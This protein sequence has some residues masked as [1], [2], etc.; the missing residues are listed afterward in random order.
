MTVE[1]ERTYPCVAFGKQPVVSVME[2]TCRVMALQSNQAAPQLMAEVQ[3]AEGFVIGV[4][5]TEEKM[6]TVGRYD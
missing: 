6:G 2:C 5:L 1:K 4:S 3:M